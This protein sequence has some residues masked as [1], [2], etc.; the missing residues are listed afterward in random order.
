MESYYLYNPIFAIKGHSLIEM[1][2]IV[3]SISA[4]MAVQKNTDTIPN[5]LSSTKHQKGLAV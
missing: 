5:H 2:F 4:T 1:L 3:K